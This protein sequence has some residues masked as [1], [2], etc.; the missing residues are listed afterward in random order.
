MG[1]GKAA[2]GFGPDQIR[3]LVY[4]AT[5]SSNMVFYGEIIVTTLAHSCLIGSSSFLLITRTTTKDCPSASGKISIYFIWEKCCDHSSAFIFK[6][7]FFFLAG[8][9]DNHKSLDEFEFQPDPI[10][11]YGVNCP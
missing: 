11:D 10:T 8:N 7:I 4:M 3:T 5:D 2:L 1:R 9:K 6:W